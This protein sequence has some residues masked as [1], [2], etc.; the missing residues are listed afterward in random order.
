MNHSKSALIII[1]LAFGSNVYGQALD[2]KA[3]VQKAVSVS[4]QVR[5]AQAALASKQALIKASRYPTPAAL[6]LAPGIGYTNGN[7]ALS[8]EIDFFGRRSSKEALARGEASVAEVELARAQAIVAESVLELASRYLMAKDLHETSQSAA[9]AAVELLETASKLNSIGEAPK[10]HVTRA[11]LEVLR[12]SQMAAMSGAELK[13][14][15]GLLNMTLG[16]PADSQV[17]FAAWTA[18]Q[19]AL[20]N[21]EALSFEILMAKA[22]FELAQSRVQSVKNES[23]PTVTA[24]VTSDVWSLDRRQWSS[25][26]WGLQASIRIPLFGRSQSRQTVLAAEEGTRESEALVAE[27]IRRAEGAKAEAVILL[28]AAQG[29]SRAYEKYIIPKAAAL[30][31]DLRKGYQ[32]G[33][34]TLLEV[35]EAQDT[36]LN[37]KREKAAS[38]R[39]QRT[40]EISLMKAV[41][42]LPGLE[43]TK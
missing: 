23:K 15:S 14:V 37:L 43:V 24:G 41:M 11:E 20:T 36:L 29:V 10:S 30:V 39:A 27:A 18:P 21:R 17:V 12:S 3:L 34:V 6:E 26:D 42:A 25:D 13:A 1:M 2:S 5:A 19:E 28:Q 22:E 7:F 16:E 32:A 35:V 4:S 8:Q 40:A 38:D 33:L 9:Q 31:A